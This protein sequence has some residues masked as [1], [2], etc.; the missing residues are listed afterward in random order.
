MMIN[1][2]C[3]TLCQSWG[4]EPL[5]WKWKRGRILGIGGFSVVHLAIRED[6]GLQFAVKS[7]AAKAQNDFE[8]KA[9]KALKNEIMLLEKLQST[10]IVKYI[11]LSLVSTPRI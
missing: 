3:H 1:M 9:L 2:D 4:L 7:V 8:T 11:F 5:D 6:D 10:Y